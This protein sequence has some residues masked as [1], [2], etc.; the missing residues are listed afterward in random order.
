MIGQ[1]D[2]IW[3]WHRRFGHINFDNL[4]KVSS[5]GY[6]RHMP[7]ITKPTNTICDEFQKGK[8]TKVSFKTKEYS[9]TRPLELVH[10][11]LCGSTRTRSLNGDKYFMLLID[12]YSRMTWV[13]FLQEK[14]QEFESFKVFKKM[15]EKESGFKLKCL[16]LKYG[17][18]FT[19]NQFEDYCEQHGI[20]RQYSSTRTPQQNGVVERKQELCLMSQIY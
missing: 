18:E 2:E 8:Q 15:V 5:K 12:D 9:T 17:G 3:L 14:S 19:S 6:V 10:T 7:K 11:N 4:V 1:V 13:T 20:R 16:R